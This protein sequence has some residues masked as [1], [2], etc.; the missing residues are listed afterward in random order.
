LRRDLPTA[1]LVAVALAACGGAE[2]SP[3][4]TSG[5]VPASTAQPA[6]PTLPDGVSAID[7][8]DGIATVTLDGP[9]PTGPDLVALVEQLTADGSARWVRFGDEPG[10]VN[11]T[12]AA[13]GQD[14]P[15]FLELNRVEVRDG[16]VAFAG[17]ADVFEAN[18]QIRLVQR[19]SVLAESFVTATCGTGCR[20]SFEGSIVPPPGAS[21]PA[22]LEAFTLSA[23][24]GSVQDVVSRDVTLG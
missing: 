13:T 3:P 11:G 2:P 9:V 24:D 17:T 7:V 4:A 12:I 14:A 21:G 8:A 22:R 16:E 1:M 23:E 20:G 15:P 10:L 6:A 18:V 19:D 5:A